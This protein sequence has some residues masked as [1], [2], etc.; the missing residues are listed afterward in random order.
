M[1]I[2]NGIERDSQNK[3]SPITRCCF[4]S[5]P[6]IAHTDIIV[7]ATN[8]RYSFFLSP[9]TSDFITLLNAISKERHGTINI[10]Q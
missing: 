6:N 4:I 7:S 1:Q 9:E 2:S 8:N 5:D 10:R 3:R